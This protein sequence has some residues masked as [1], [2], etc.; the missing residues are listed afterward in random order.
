MNYNGECQ[1]TAVLSGELS[2]RPKAEKKKTSC[3]ETVQ[4]DTKK[5]QQKMQQSAD[6]Y[7]TVYSNHRSYKHT[8]AS[9]KED[10][11]K[12]G[13]TKTNTKNRHEAHT[14]IDKRAK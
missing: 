10:E 11:K 12:K 14:R 5:I 9:A 6:L 4:R 2:W 13:E 1:A 7:L 8:P 3:S